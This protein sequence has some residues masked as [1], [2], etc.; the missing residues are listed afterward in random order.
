MAVAPFNA[1]DDVRLRG[2]GKAAGEED[3]DATIKLRRRLAAALATDIKGDDRRLWRQAA[4]A[5]AVVAA[6]STAVVAGDYGGDGRLW[7]RRKVQR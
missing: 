6:L 3:S 1:W 5:V 7:R 4:A 2:G